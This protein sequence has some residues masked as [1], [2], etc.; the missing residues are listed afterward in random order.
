[1]VL[2]ECTFHSPSHV[3]TWAPDQIHLCKMWEAEQGRG[4]LLLPLGSPLGVF[5]EAAAS[6]HLTDVVRGRTWGICC[7]QALASVTLDSSPRSAT[8]SCETLG[9]LFNFSVPQIPIIQWGQ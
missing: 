7:L 2:S 9:K 3:P 8:S 1:M 6:G 5:T 4:T